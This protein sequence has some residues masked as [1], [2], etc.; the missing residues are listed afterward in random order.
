MKLSGHVKCGFLFFGR[1]YPLMNLPLRCTAS[2]DIAADCSLSASLPSLPSP[3]PVSPVTCL[4]DVQ[5]AFQHLTFL[6]SPSDY[7]SSARVSSWV[8]FEHH[9]FQGQQF[10]LE[11]GEYPNWEAYSGSLS[12]HTER[13]MSLRPIYCAVSTCRGGDG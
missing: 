6:Y 5:T 4:S 13:F 9:D 7:F 8:G 3:C 11:R 10:I 2:W 1:T 12:Y